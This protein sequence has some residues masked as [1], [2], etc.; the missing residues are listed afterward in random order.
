MIVVTQPPLLLLGHS[1]AISAKDS[2]VQFAPQGNSQDSH[3]V[4]EEQ[5]KPQEQDG[6]GGDEGGEG[7]SIYA[8]AVG[9]TCVGVILV[10]WAQR[11]HSGEEGRTD[12]G[13]SKAR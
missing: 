6:V 12:R 10:I 11:R 8:Y 2:R 3:K 13:S 7:I 4:R 1:F 5:R 9:L